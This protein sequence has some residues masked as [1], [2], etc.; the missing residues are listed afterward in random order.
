M[1]KSRV[2]GDL[3]SFLRE[4]KKF[5]MIPILV[6]F[7]LLGFLVFVAQTTPLAPFIYTLY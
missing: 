5:W 7:I 2:L 6:V 4:Q 1:A 3:W